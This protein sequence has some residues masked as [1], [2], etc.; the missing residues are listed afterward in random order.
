MTRLF[1]FFIHKL[2]KNTRIINLYKKKKVNRLNHTCM[3]LKVCQNQSNVLKLN[4]LATYTTYIIIR[5]SKIIS[6]L[7][8]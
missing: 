2:C 7:L 8:L 4:Q 3:T 6:Y 1:Y 5:L